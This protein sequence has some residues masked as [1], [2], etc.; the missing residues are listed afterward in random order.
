VHGGL[1]R[2]LHLSAGTEWLRR[3]VRHPSATDR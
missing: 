3:V 2:R 1:S